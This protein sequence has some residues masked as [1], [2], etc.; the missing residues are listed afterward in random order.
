[1]MSA[2]QRYALSG[3][4]SRDPAAG[5]FAD[6]AVVVPVADLDAILAQGHQLP[7]GGEAR[8]GARAGVL[9]W[10][11]HNPPEFCT[12]PTIAFS[13]PATGG[14]PRARFVDGRHRYT[15]LRDAGADRIAIGC[16][17]PWARWW[18]ARGGTA[19]EIGGPGGRAIGGAIFS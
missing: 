19:P 3:R 4:V 6:S 5:G 17:R 13:M 8:P 18:L 2:A 12:A 11:A 1:M 10:F 14:I 15:V 16:Q 7:A 9:N